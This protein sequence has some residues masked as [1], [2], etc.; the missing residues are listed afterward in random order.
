MLL[1]P[2]GVADWIHYRSFLRPG[3]KLVQAGLISLVLSGEATAPDTFI[4]ADVR[5]TI[6]AFTRLVGDEQ[7]LFE[8]ELPAF[9]EPPGSNDG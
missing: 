3:E 4:S 2:A 5:L 7:I 1:G 9:E 8:T 6:P